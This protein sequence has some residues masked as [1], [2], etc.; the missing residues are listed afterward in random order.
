MRVITGSARGRRLRAPAGEAVR[1]TSA[2][3]KEAIFSAVQFGVEGAHVLDL[4]AGSGQMGIEAL[5]RG[6]RG[7]VFVDNSKESLNI[8]RENLEATGPW[9][10]GRVTPADAVS[11][12]RG[13]RGDPFDL[14]FLDPPYGAGLLKTALP[15]TAGLMSEGGVIFCETDC[16]TK[17]PEG[18]GELILQ[19]EYRY[20]KIKVAKYT[21]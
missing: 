17:L 2:I 3:V 20:G 4:F 16:E 14:A 13:Y 19:K 10:T 15:L 7:C 1:P 11:F 21:R 12:L 5:S 6:A 18:C 8:L 9:P